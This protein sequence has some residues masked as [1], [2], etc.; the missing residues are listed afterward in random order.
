MGK[1]T[2][3]KPRYCINMIKPGKP[4]NLQACFY[5]N[6]LCAEFAGVEPTTKSLDVKVEKEEVGSSKYADLYR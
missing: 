2:E 5:Y 3:G 6:K 4:I 1:F